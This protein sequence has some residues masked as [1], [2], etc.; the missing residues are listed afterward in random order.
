MQIKEIKDLKE[1]DVLF[2]FET[3]IE[4]IVAIQILQVYNTRC[5]FRV[6]K[7]LYN[8]ESFN[9]RYFKFVNSNDYCNEWGS[10]SVDVFIDDIDDISKIIENKDRIRNASLL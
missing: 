5:I 4:S 2:L 3:K 6:I 1:Y 7:I 8:A 10:L 9:R